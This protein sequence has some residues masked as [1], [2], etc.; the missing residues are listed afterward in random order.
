VGRK[1][2]G[3][4]LG[5]G[6]FYTLSDVIR[7]RHETRSLSGVIGFSCGS[8]FLT[9]L[10]HAKSTGAGRSNDVACIFVC[11]PYWNSDRGHEGLC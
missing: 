9:V 2:K 8:F 5:T 11:R 10:L 4:D 1:Q 6:R 7:N 3:P